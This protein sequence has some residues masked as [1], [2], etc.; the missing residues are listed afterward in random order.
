[1]SNLTTIVAGTDLAAGHV[2]VGDAGGLSEVYDI[3]DSSSIPGLLAVETE[4]GML[5]LDPENDYT[6]KVD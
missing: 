1:M 2:L 6:V 3:E 4:H 5:Y